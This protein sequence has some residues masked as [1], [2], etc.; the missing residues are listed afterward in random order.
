MKLLL[1]AKPDL[2]DKIRSKP[3]R[4]AVKMPDEMMQR[5][6]IK[7]IRFEDGRVAVEA[8]LLKL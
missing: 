2:K 6:A 3:G 5:V 1:K 8:G 4:L 7:D